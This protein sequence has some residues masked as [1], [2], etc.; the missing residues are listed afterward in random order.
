MSMAAKIQIAVIIASIVFV[1][2][3]TRNYDYTLPSKAVSRPVLELP[4]YYEA[5]QIG[6]ATY[7]IKREE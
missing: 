3:M 1:F 2:Y 6:R 7:K 5:E 4:R